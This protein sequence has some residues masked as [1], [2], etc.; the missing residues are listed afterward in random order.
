[1]FCLFG[2]A[3]VVGGNR[4]L[5]GGVGIH[6]PGWWAALT[7]LPLAGV[8]VARTWNEERLLVAELAGYREYMARTKYRLVPLVW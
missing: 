4:E 7:V 8:L 5:L 2:R 1:M 3:A 6:G